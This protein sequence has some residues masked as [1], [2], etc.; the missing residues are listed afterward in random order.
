MKIL[1]YSFL[2]NNS[3]ETNFQRPQSS[4]C[5]FENELDK[6]PQRFEL[7][8]D[9]LKR[10]A[11][12][13]YQ[14]NLLP[15]GLVASSRVRTST[16]MSRHGEASEGLQTTETRSKRVFWCFR[17][18]LTRLSSECEIE[19]LPNDFGDTKR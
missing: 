14:E 19:K 4:L 2:L 8:S 9:W 10:T 1:R 3:L 12:A 7:D 13:S 5:S 17:S 6:K 15:K 16:S 11:L 18:C